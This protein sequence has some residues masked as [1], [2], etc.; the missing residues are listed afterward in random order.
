M[1]G[2]SVNHDHADIPHGDVHRLQAA[3][4]PCDLSEASL[5]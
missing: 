3:D 5:N 2:A 4:R 1:M